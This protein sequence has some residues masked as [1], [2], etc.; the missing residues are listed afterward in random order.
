MN[1]LKSFIHQVIDCG[2]LADPN[3]GRVT[4]LNGTLVGSIAIYTCDHGYGVVGDVSRRC[5]D[6]GSW[7]G[8]TTCQGE[9]SLNQIRV[10]IREF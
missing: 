9:L 8:H 2:P 5:Q 7:S 6:N 3:Y 4:L 1:V 10:L